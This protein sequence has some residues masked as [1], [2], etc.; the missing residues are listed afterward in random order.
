[1]FIFS[2]FLAKVNLTQVIVTYTSGEEPNS[3]IIPGFGQN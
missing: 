1:M 3:K 2:S